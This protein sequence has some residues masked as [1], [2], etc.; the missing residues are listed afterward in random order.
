MSF[1]ACQEVSLAAEPRSSIRAEPSTHGDFR[2][3][4]ISLFI[5]F[6]FCLVSNIVTTLIC[7]ELYL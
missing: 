3:Y 6:G 1:P 5:F 4:K 2:F 7:L